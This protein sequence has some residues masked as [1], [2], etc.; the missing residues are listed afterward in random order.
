MLFFRICYN[1]LNKLHILSL[2]YS[3][4]LEFLNFTLKIMRATFEWTNWCFP[5]SLGIS[6]L[7]ITLFTQKKEIS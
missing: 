5:F 2:K 1:N 3:L 4:P 6:N 7:E